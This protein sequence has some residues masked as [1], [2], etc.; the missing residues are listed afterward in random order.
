MDERRTIWELEQRRLI[1]ETLLDYCEYVDRN[2]PGTLV[3]KVFA[4]DGVFELG[5]DRAVVGRDDLACMFAKTLCAF[6]AT[7]H[8]LSNVR[9]ELEA[10]D[11]A[12]AT[13]YVYAWHQALDGRR[14]DVWGRYRD[15]LRLTD[16]GWRI[17]VRRLTMAGTDGWLEAP[18]EGLDRQ[19]NPVDPPS[20]RVERR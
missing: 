9:I 19:P 11:L 8:H 1:T 16:E 15:Q 5:A 14:V 10:D 6:T 17:T 12:R 18:F 7:S 2:D 4:V 3:A 20:P 13:A